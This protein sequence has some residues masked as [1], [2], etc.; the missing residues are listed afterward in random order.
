MM[1]RYLVR[2]VRLACRSFPER[3]GISHSPKEF[4]S[5]ADMEKGIEVL[6]EI[7]YKLAY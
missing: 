1:H 5:V 4:T 6:S 2:F 7:L 3:G